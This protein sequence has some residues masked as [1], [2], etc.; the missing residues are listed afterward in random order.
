MLLEQGISVMHVVADQKVPRQAMHTLEE[1]RTWGT[2]EDL[3]TDR[4]DPQVCSDVWLCS[5]SFCV[6]EKVPI[7]KQHGG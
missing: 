1:A 7:N 2:A 3:T 4:Q 6:E 5:D